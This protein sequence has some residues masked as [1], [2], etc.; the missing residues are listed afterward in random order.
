MHRGGEFAATEGQNIAWVEGII[1]EGWGPVQ[2]T[3]Y[4][5][6]QEE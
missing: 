3:P 5:E 1:R 2:Q 6:E 4:P